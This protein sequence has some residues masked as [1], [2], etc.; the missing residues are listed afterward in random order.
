MGENLANFSKKLRNFQVQ[1]FWLKNELAVVG[2]HFVIPL[3]HRFVQCNDN[4]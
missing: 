1:V 2:G 4:P 3:C